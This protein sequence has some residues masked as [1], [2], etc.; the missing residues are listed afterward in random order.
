MILWF[1]IIGTDSIIWS[2]LMCLGFL[3]FY[4]MI[5]KGTHMFH[6]N[7]RLVLSDCFAER[8]IIRK[9][10]PWCTFSWEGNAGFSSPEKTTGVIVEWM[11]GNQQNF[12]RV[13]EKCS[14]FIGFWESSLFLLSACENISTKQKTAIHFCD[15]SFLILYALI[16]FW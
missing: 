11:N 16:C 5:K 13:T 9:L 8:Q 14:D 4:S 12:S 1:Y 15:R 10:R 3:L 2:L 6:W 7:K